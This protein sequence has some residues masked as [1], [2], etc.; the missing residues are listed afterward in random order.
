MLGR[1]IKSIT[2][3]TV[4]SVLAWSLTACQSTSNVTVFGGS[5]PRD[6]EVDAG[7]KLPIYAYSLDKPSVSRCYGECLRYFK[8]IAVVATNVSTDANAFRRNDGII[9]R[10]L[11][12]R[13]LYTSTI[14]I[15]GEYP[16][17]HLIHQGWSLVYR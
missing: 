5:K 11:H 4:T 16:R 10:Q 12:G 8:P 2:S 7:S 17:A 6:F 1:T 14:D 15:P 3:L 9:Q 13:P